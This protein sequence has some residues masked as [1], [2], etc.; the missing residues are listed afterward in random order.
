MYSYSNAVYENLR[1][2]VVNSDAIH[3]VRVIAVFPVFRLLYDF[4][5]LF[6]TLIFDVIA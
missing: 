3:H 5:N 4:V 2:D 1:F 6:I